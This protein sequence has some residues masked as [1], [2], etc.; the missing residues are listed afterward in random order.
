[1]TDNK[2]M[3][4]KTAGGRS[5]YTFPILAFPGLIANIYIIDDGNGLTLVDCGSGMEQSNE[6]LLAGF[7]T[8]QSQYGKSLGLKEIRTIIITHGHM[9]HFGGLP[10]VRQFTDAPIGVHPLDRRVLSNYEERVIVASRQL[11]NFLE[12]AGVSEQEQANLMGMYLWAK[13]RYHS[14][15]V[16]FSLEETQPLFDEIPLYHV[17]G[18]CPGQVCLLVD[19]ILLTAD[20]VLSRTTP[21]QAPE[22]ITNH[23]GLSHYLDSLA[24]IETM[25]GVRLAL[26]GHEQPMT[27]LP[28]RIQEIRQVHTERLNKILDICREPHS[29]ADISKALFGRVSS[30]HVLLALEEAGAHVEHLYQRGELAAANLDEIQQA[31]HPIIAYQSA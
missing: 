15:P 28:G 27:D 30:Y 29:I 10:F 22:S 5:I 20:H 6:E 1:M 13:D 31:D 24:K 19:D 25:T 21:H 7:E 11:K 9:D 14:T 12:R 18:H 16:Q 3:H 8:L 4:Y 26:G 17:P 2:V 23:M